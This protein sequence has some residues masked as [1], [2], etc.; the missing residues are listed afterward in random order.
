MLVNDYCDN[1]DDATANLDAI[2]FIDCRGLR[3]T[4]KGLGLLDYISTDVCLSVEDL[5]KKQH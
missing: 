3:A 5:L 2:S 1:N 4:F